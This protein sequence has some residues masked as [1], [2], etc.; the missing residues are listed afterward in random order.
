MNSVCTSCGIKISEGGVFCKKCSMKKAWV[1]GTYNNRPPIKRRIQQNSG[2]VP[3]LKIG[4]DPLSCL[5]FVYIL[6]ADNGIYKIGRT[7]NLNNRISSI[8]GILPY[9]TELIHAIET[10]DYKEAERYFHR[11]FAHRCIRGEWFQLTE[12]DV[13]QLKQISEYPI[14]KEEENMTDIEILDRVLQNHYN[15]LVWE[16]SESLFALGDSG[17]PMAMYK[18]ESLSDLVEVLRLEEMKE[19]LT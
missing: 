4:L 3:P 1:R 8:N 2:S 19:K 16:R 12:K 17:A 13:E 11:K 6:K 15:C 18:A 10:E 7:K 5:G 9:D 14:R